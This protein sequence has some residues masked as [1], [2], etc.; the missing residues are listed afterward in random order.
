MHT[1]K[2]INEFACLKMCF[3]VAP[4]LTI[5]TIFNTLILTFV[6]LMKI[7]ATAEFINLSIDFVTKGI[8]KF[9]LIF[10]IVIVVFSTGYNQIENT[11]SDVISIKI[12]AK[13][14]K[15][16]GMMRMEKMASMAYFNIENPDTLDLIRRTENDG[17]IIFHIYKAILNAIVIF[18]EIVSVFI[19]IMT[20]SIV[21]SV[22]VFIVSIPL[23]W[24]AMKAGEK[25]YHMEKDVTIY[26]RQYEYYDGLQKNRDSVDE[27]TLFNYGTFV[28]KK[29]LTSYEKFRKKN[30]LLT[31]RNNVNIE[32]GS[33]V[34]SLFT[35]VVASM[36]LFSYYKGEISLGLFLSLFAAIVGLT[37]AMSWGFSEAVS[38]VTNNHQ[39]LK[40]INSFFSLLEEQNAITIKGNSDSKEVK[41]I[42]FKNV[43]FKYP[44]MDYYVIK[45][46]SL[47]ITAGTHYAFVGKNGAGKSTIIKL[48]TGLYRNYEGEILINGKE[49]KEYGNNELRAFFSIVYQ[50]FAKYQV[51]MHDNIMFGDLQCSEEKIQEVIK[52]CGLN[53]IVQ[54]IGGDINIPLGKIIEGGVDLSGGE[55]Q[56]IAIAR[57]LI[58]N[59]NSLI[60]DEPTSALDPL[61]E[62][63]LYE[64]FHSICQDK[65]TIFISH[66]LGSTKL[67]D[68]ILVIEDGKVEE[69]GTHEELMNKGNLYEDMYNSQR[70]WYE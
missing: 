31:I 66:R 3:S 8:S 16:Y 60:L 69:M 19:A 22:L 64:Q 29:M 37:E 25:Q 63:K 34:T 42:E 32:S 65:T 35:I 48:L 49:L 40:D 33:V 41:S 12:I 24:I 56:K 67:A 7:C 36:L 46:L 20:S 53:Q 6:P 57:A 4:V 13:L 47:K 45:G 39:Q 23:I 62:N 54:K 28:E 18:S 17:Q 61:M 27:R 21:M 50:D 5:M 51:S 11:I 52:V 68:I 2:K 30:I 58:K 9:E 43:W 59:S 38:D 10:P 1:N 70:K 15:K 44:N 55:W 14:R 26:K